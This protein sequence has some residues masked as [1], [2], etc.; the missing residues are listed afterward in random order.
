MHEAPLKKHRSTSWKIWNSKF[1]NRFTFH[2][3]DG[4]VDEKI[5]TL[6]CAIQFAQISS[7]ITNVTTELL[8]EFTNLRSFYVGSPLT[9]DMIFNAE[10]V[11]SIIT[12]LS[13][14]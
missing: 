12:S 10:L 6:K 8:A 1:S 4:C 14:F 2:Q 9:Q 13:L 5:I 7:N 11:D 3:I